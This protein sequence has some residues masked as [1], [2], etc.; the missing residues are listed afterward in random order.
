MISFRAT[1]KGSMMRY[2]PKVQPEP[3]EWLALDEQERIG[4]VEAYHRAVRTKLP[5]VAAHAC[6]H[7][8][9]EN[10]IAEG[11]E[12]LVR[13]IVRLMKEGLSR[14]DAVHAIGSVG[15]DHFYEGR[16]SEDK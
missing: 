10:Q 6:L 15:A 1:T 12:P 11:L 9:V 13:A 5:N 8:I 7:A 3:S 16:H 4:L 2:D 14:H